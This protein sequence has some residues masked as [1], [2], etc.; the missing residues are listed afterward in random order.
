MN[1][2]DEKNIKVFNYNE[3]KL[4]FRS[5]IR[6]YILPV[7]SINEPTFDFITFEEIEYINSNTNGI[8]TGLIRFEKDK[9]KAI[10]KELGI[11]GTK[12]IKNEEIEDILLNPT[13]EGMKKILDITDASTFQRLKYIF[14]RLESSGSDISMQTVRIIR[15][16]ID[17]MKKGIISTK[18][19]LYDE[20]IVKDKKSETSRL[21]KEIEQLK[22]MISMLTKGKSSKDKEIEDNIEEDISD[23]TYT[24][25]KKGRPKKNV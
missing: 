15:Q 16:R 24:E 11:D 2:R 8:K 25:T 4:C 17:E 20:D 12:I 9:E 1:I 22:S 19:T 14:S 21:E 18:I 13:K 6:S 3:T 23:T 10:Y 5:N 7:G